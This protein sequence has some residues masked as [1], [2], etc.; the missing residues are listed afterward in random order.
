VRPDI[1]VSTDIIVGF[2]GETDRDFEQTMKLV[3]DIGFDGAFSFVYSTRPGTPAADLEDQV[4]PA[5]SQRRLTELQALL[6]AQ[7]RTRSDAELAQTALTAAGIA[8]AIEADDAGG[9]Y[10]FVLAGA[11]RLFVA[12]AD[13]ALATAILGADEPAESHGE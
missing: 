3:Q 9:A 11:A 6:E 8:S 12:E 13:A 4:P 7:Y 10:P 2:P 1:A 5:V